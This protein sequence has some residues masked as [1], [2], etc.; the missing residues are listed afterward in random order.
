MNKDKVNT[1]KSFWRSYHGKRVTVQVP[2]LDT[3]LAARR[4]LEVLPRLEQAVE[5]L[6][7][8]LAPSKVQLEEPIQVCLID[9]GTLEDEADLQSRA[10][11]DIHKAP[12]MDP[13]VHIMRPE[14]HD[15]LLLLAVTRTLVRR[16]VGQNAVSI[17]FFL[18]GI[19]GIIAARSGIGLEV[20][21]IN[22]TLRTELLNNHTISIFAATQKTEEVTQSMTSNDIATS[23][24]AFLIDTYG[25]SALKQ[26]L[27]ADDANR[28]DQAA[29]VA[30][31]RSLGQLEEL[32]LTNLRKSANSS[33]TF[34]LFI[35]RIIPLLK[36]YWLR[37]IE[38]LLY[39]IVG[40]SFN[41]VIPFSGKFIIDTVI[42][43]KNI[44][45]LLLFAGGMFSFLIVN[46]LIAIRRSQVTSEIAQR[47]TID[48]QEK[49]YNHLQKL[50]HHFYSRAKVGDL[51]SRLTTDAEI[52]QQAISQVLGNGFFMICNAIVG[53]VVL[54][55]LQPIIGGM[56]I[57]I[58]PLM[59]I[60]IVLLGSRFKKISADRQKLVGEVASTIQENI[61]AHSV[62]RAFG[63]EQ[64][65]VALYHARLLLKLKTSIRM[66][67]ASA[68]F[69]N[70]LILGSLIAQVI[71]ISVGGYLVIQSHLTIG[72]VLAAWTV[73]PT[74]FIPIAIFGALVGTVLSASG[75]MERI[76]ELQDEPVTITDKPNAVVLPPITK[77]IRLEGVKFGYEN[78]LTVLDELNISIPAG[79]NIAIVGPS[80]SGKSSIVNLLMRFWDAWEGRI[81]F[82]GY[83][84]RNVTV[85]SLRGQIGLVFQ[86]TF[87][88]DTTFR[89]NIAIGCPGA[90]DSEVIAA[91][92][93]ARLDEYINSLPS[94]YNT[95]LGER[96][97]RM[98]GGQR[99]R[100]AIARA[101]LRNP[102]VLILDEAT[103]ALDAQTEREILETL[104]ELKHDRT[105]ISI[106]H[107]LSIASAADHILVLDHGK[108]IEQGS[109]E[110]LLQRDG[111]Y[112][113]LY[114]EQIEHSSSVSLTKSGISPERLRI[115]PL[116]KELSGEL[117]E[118]LAKQLVRKRYG[119]D[120]Y[121]VRQGEP[122]D[123]F[124]II[125]YG[126]VEVLLN[127]HHTKRRIGI[128]D[129]GDFFGEMS[130]LSDEPRT[131]SVRTTFPTECYSLSRTAFSA[132]L[133]E[134]PQI[135]ETISQY[136][137]QRRTELSSIQAFMR[138]PASTS[139]FLAP[140]M[141]TLVS[142]SQVAQ[143]RST[144]N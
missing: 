124:Y 37:E 122:G 63:L 53:L 2:D 15:E 125:N 34:L 84:L 70:T 96:G 33:S 59:S 29:L 86:D 56:V 52:V 19:A 113:Q 26:F 18:N 49:S 32:W 8:F 47:V 4:A 82:D 80:G 48:L 39:S 137:N 22:S 3:S 132:L 68:V 24:M 106:T 98:S 120:E 118:K 20:A 90:T 100:L 130:L 27:A 139:Y 60:A 104:D 133:D 35:Q 23:F 128:L 116:F 7:K 75:S 21:R 5:E 107:R 9:P 105:T 6:I 123:T 44:P 43:E 17:P 142:L 54:L 138:Q 131:A 58:I 94:G 95:V 85:A 74:L 36:P 57:A 127:D 42:P 102:H 97:V 140:N 61:S 25:A 108:L 38:V 143:E 115:I 78:D 14:E 89:E 99:Q 77:E 109:H 71:V 30:Y 112:R 11:N 41:V 135:Q 110:E 136:M 83:D 55:S 12:G 103:S 50:S 16:W 93:G 45:L 72:T 10:G 88:F 28:Q 13:I 76:I 51:M 121:V 66:A 67:V 64:S 65:A 129:E 111:L 40:L 126:Q 31:Q 101:L 114:Q 117:L 141:A 92:R 62:V 91:A 46:T 87:I 134:E 119:M 69:E 144:K 73:L 81:L 1:D 79:A